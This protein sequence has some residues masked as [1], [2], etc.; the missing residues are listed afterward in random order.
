MGPLTVRQVEALRWLGDG[1]PDGVWRDFTYK[2]TNYALAARELA[3]VD[4]R[5]NSW[6]PTLTDAGRLYLAQGRYP[7]AETRIQA[8][9]SGNGCSRTELVNAGRDLYWPP[10]LP[11]RS[12]T[13]G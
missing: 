12:I 2:T 13:N 1:C 6:S 9:P 5:R 7:D 11:A 3:T 8:D 10:N 4:R